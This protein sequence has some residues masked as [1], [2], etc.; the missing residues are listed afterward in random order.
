LKKEIVYIEQQPLGSN[1]D[2]ELVIAS[3]LWLGNIAARLDQYVE[4]VFTQW[5]GC[6]M[7]AFLLS[8]WKK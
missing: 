5:V 1:I 3:E 7:L 2:S 4:I 6:V 8:Q